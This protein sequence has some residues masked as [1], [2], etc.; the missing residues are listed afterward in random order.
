MKKIL[1]IVICVVAV[2]Q[3]CSKKDK[4]THPVSLNDAMS[5]SAAK[6]AVE[7]QKA[8]DA[9][10]ADKSIPLTQYQEM[11]NGK[12]LLFSHLAISGMPVD[13]AKIAEN[14][15]AE[16]T[17]ESDEF[18]KRDIMNALKPGIDKEI[19]KAK[20]GRYYY[21]NIDA[22]WD[23]YDFASKSFASNNI[24]GSSRYFMFDNFAYRYKLEWSNG[25]AFSKLTVPDEGQ[26]R[27]IEALRIKHNGINT[28]IYFFLADTKLGE[29]TVLGEIT[30]VKVMDANGNVLSEI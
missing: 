6:K 25:N 4:D 15:S 22:N 18:K 17:R 26:A 14:I 19:S 8:A 3:G 9:P 29:S 28:R 11:N 16:Y 2:L 30:K 12:Q 27:T 1:A 13:Y 7:V 20:D 10:K 21:M 5:S 23:K 24:A